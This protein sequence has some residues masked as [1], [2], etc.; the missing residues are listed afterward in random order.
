MILLRCHLQCVAASDICMNLL[1]GYQTFTL[2]D[3]KLSIAVLTI[4]FFDLLFLFS[5][6][7]VLS[8]M[9]VT[10]GIQWRNGNGKAL[11]KKRE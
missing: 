11:V 9:T 6:F 4:I 8:F 10:E 3:V 7:L 5:G 1:F 2:P